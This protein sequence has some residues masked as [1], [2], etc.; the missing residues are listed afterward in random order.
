MRWW[1]CG[2]WIGKR[3]HFAAFIAKSHNNATG[4]T[5]SQPHSAAAID[6]R[7]NKNSPMSSLPAVLAFLSVSHAYKWWC[8]REAVAHTKPARISS[9]LSGVLSQY[10]FPR[11]LEEESHHCYL[12]TGHGNHQTTL[13]QAEVEDARLGALDSA[14]VAVLACAEVFLVA[15][16][17]GQLRGELEDG[18]LEDCRLLG[19][20]AL[21]G[22]NGGAGSFVLNLRR[23]SAWRGPML[24][25]LK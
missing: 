17:G 20:G 9:R 10:T 12:E 16:D 3:T 23:G 11:A 19:G 15:G 8:R 6:S 2:T 21:L 18:F 14:E 5:R 4:D 1:W 25:E 7:N 13:H 22:G 24:G